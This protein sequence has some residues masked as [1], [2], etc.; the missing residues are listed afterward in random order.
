MSK[1]KLCIVLCIALLAIATSTSFAQ[2]ITCLA[3]D[4]SDSDGC[5]ISP[6]PDFGGLRCENRCLTWCYNGACSSFC[7]CATTGSCAILPP[8]L[9]GDE[10]PERALANPSPSIRRQ[11]GAIT[12]I[13]DDLRGALLL[14]NDRLATDY[15]GTFSHQALNQPET[16]IIYRYTASVRAINADSHEV[17][18]EV[19]DH[20]TVRALSFLLYEQGKAASLEIDWQGEKRRQVFHLHS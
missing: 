9:H 10:L 8:N 12:E 15:Q 18:I 14:L 1:S 4:A 20:P 13:P 19:L 3:C 5:G 11:L 17:Q 7:F 2:D 6:W 16:R